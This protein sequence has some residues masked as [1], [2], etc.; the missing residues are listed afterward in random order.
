MENGREQQINIR[1]ERMRDKKKKS[2]EE[3]QA[4]ETSHVSLSRFDP[5]CSDF[6]LH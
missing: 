4:G 2:G 3:E 1:K 6:H 5:K